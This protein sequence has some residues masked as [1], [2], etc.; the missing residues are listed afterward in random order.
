MFYPLCGMVHIKEPL[1]LIANSSQCGSNRFPLSLPEWTFTIC[2]MPYNRMASD[3]W[4]MKVFFIM[5]FINV[6]YF[7]FLIYIY[8]FIIII[9]NF[10]IFLLVVV[11][12]LKIL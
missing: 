12:G 6:F 11:L 1:L 2:P 10:N 4:Y 8:F 7:I 5:I 9:Y 3:I